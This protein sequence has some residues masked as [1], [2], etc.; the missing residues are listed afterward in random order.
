MIKSTWADRYLGIRYVAGGA[1]REG[2]DCWGL[3]ALVYSEQLGR[4]VAPHDISPFSE[5]ADAIEY[6][7]AFFNMF[8]ALDHVGI[9]LSPNNYLIHASPQSGVCITP[10]LQ[11]VPIRSKIPT[12]YRWTQ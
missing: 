9:V 11:S 2:L 10:V 5:V 12:F 6:D 1:T 7:V 8:P 3:V 4:D